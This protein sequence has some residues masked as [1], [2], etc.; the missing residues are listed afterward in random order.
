MTKS[1]T[2][3][4]IRNTSLAAISQ[5]INTLLSFVARTIFIKTLGAEYL[6]ANGLF[7]NILT[8]LSFAEL[9]IG[10]AI[11]FSLY[12]P[13]AEKDEK[14]IKQLMQLYK[15]AYN[16]IG[17][18]VLLMGICI[19]PF[20]NIIVK[21]AP[22]IKENIAFIYLLFLI[23]TVF[24]YFFTYKKSIIIAN[25][26]DYL[27]NIFD[28]I[29]YIIKT[30]LQCLFLYLTH[31]YVIYLIIQI[32]CTLFENIIISI[33]ANKMY[34]YLKDKEIEK[35]S[36]DE[37]NGIFQNVKALVF[38]KFGS[39]ILNGTDNILISVMLGVTCVG[40]VSNYTLIITAITNIIGQL[41]NGFISSIGNLN[42]IGTKNAKERT[43]NDI[44]FISVWIYGF[45]SVGLL[46]FLN[47]FIRIWLGEAYI[48]EYIVIIAL[49]LHFYVNGV[50]FVAYAYRTTMGLFI[51][52]KYTAIL[53]AV[54]NI[55]LSII[56]CKFMGLSGI[57]FAT[58]IARL[59]TTAWYDPFMIYSREFNKKVKKY[60]IK[61]VKYF[62]III[63]NYLC[64]EFII[65]RIPGSGMLNFTI[66][67]CIFTIISNFIF[68]MFFFK[69]NEFRNVC[70]RVKD[71]LKNKFMHNEIPD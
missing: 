23:N 64:S 13:I 54:I 63:I 39:V 7:T 1:R 71:L 14:K 47:K 9:G 44:F 51:Y 65:N 37:R 20:L 45:C 57:F 32:A 34:P 55:F 62:V 6:G 67:L 38:Y 19:I 18:I 24:S 22:T 66:K 8:I 29:F 27:I 12:K 56:L 70:N 28:I 33:K 61:Y 4:S 10:N 16:T 49:V 17:I 42:A 36:K 30:V 2:I 26:N 15:K 43:F 53:A 31:N 35:I 11:I 40:L 68:F 69:T 41:L 5:I 48:L 3:N 60:Y 46:I 52:G 50:Q 59:L 21:E 25:Q 58:T